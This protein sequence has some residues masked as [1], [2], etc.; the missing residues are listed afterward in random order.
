MRLEARTAVAFTLAAE[1]A[2]APVVAARND[3]QINT[4]THETSVSTDV[5]TLS[6]LY[7]G[8]I[9]LNLS[10]APSGEQLEEK[11]SEPQMLDG[12]IIGLHREAELF[13]PHRNLAQASTTSSERALEVDVISDISLPHDEQSTTVLPLDL[14]REAHFVPVLGAPYQ[15]EL[16]NIGDTTISPDGLHGGVYVQAVD[17]EGNPLTTGLDENPIFL[18]QDQVLLN[19]PEE[20]ITV[21]NG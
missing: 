13:M 11:G 7:D 12:D 15:S 1:L 14:L 16:D 10:L 6:S 20:S 8:R 21:A 4:S 3:A 2:S 17:S 5:D 9:K 19:V 18:R